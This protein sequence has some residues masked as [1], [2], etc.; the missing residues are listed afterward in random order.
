MKNSE[1]LTKYV[2]NTKQKGF[3]M[4][5]KIN[6]LKYQMECLQ[7][8]LNN[9]K[10]SLETPKTKCKKVCYINPIHSIFIVILVIVLFKLHIS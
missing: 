6:R 1:Y 3:I 9:M 5:H 10:Q 4:K 7:Q 2:Q 8:D